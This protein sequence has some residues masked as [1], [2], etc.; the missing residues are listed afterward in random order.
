M[1][2]RVDART[3]PLAAL[4]ACR[5]PGPG[6]AGV[7]PWRRRGDRRPRGRG[8]AGG[9]A[10]RPRR[11][12]R[13]AARRAGAV[14]A[15][16]P[17]QP[18][19]HRVG[20]GRPRGRA[21]AADRRARPA[22][23]HARDDRAVGDA[24]RPAAGADRDG[25]GPAGVL[26]DRLPPGGRGADP[27]RRRP[28]G[29]AAVAAAPR[30]PRAAARP[31]ASGARLGRRGHPAAVRHRPPRHPRRRRARARVRA[32]DEPRLRREDVHPPRPARDREP[33]LLAERARSW[34]RPRRSSTRS[35]PGSATV[36]APWPS[37]AG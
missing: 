4:R 23:D 21:R 18:A 22:E 11:R 2:R 15:A 12:G 37:T 8:R 1:R 13:A 10:A 9:Q 14:G 30:R 5:Q 26:R 6:R 25:C 24:R 3:S 29:R 34:P 20:P 27:G 19:G 36:E 35:R 33:G 7:R 28:V 32:R 16:A 31:L 17:G